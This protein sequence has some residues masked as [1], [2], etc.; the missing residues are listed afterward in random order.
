MRQTADYDV[1]A[2]LDI[3][4]VEQAYAAAREFATVVRA[5]L[6]RRAGA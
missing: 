4:N 3:G 1:R 5:A 2:D 6:G